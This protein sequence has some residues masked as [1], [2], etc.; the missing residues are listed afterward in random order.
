M[1]RLAAARDPAAG[2]RCHL[3]DGEGDGQVYD[4]WGGFLASSQEIGSRL[5]SVRWVKAK[6][7]NLRKCGV[8]VCD[9][10]ASRIRLAGNLPQAIG[11]G[12]AAAAIG[13]LAAV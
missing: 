2:P 10:C 8:F 9:R 1:S 7:R 4:F 13:S 6:S 11:W 3:C 5:S 12:A